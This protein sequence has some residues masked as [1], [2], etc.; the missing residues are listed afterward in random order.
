MHIVPKVHQ[1]LTLDA[2]PRPS[3]R[4]NRLYPDWRLVGKT[5]SRMSAPRTRPRSGTESGRLVARGRRAASH[6]GTL[7]PRLGIAYVVR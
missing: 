5:I 2:F 3:H 7:G 6:V 4:Q 1:D